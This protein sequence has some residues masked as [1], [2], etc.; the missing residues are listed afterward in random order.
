MMRIRGVI[1]ICF[2]VSLGFSASVLAAADE[3]EII[4]AA[5]REGR[6]VWYT[7]AGESQQLA[8]EFERKYPFVKVE[9]VRCIPSGS[10]SCPC[11]L[12]SRTKRTTGKSNLAESSGFRIRL[13][14]YRQTAHPD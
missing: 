9:V 5:K 14:K 8:Q 4:Q 3:T 13:L 10:S 2:F 7:V 12:I 11:P 6:V 1:T